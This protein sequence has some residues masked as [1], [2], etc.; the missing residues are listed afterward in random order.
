MRLNQV[1]KSILKTIIWFDLFDRPLLKHEVY[2][3]LYGFR[4]CQRKID[5]EIANLIKFKILDKRKNHIFLRGKRGLV[6]NQAKAERHSHAKINYLKLKAISLLSAVPFIKFVGVTGSVAYSVANKNSDIDLFIITA[7]KRLWLA[8]LFTNLNL[9]RQGFRKLGQKNRIC[10]NFLVSQD[11]LN[12]EAIFPYL[13]DKYWLAT[14]KPIAGSGY[15]E[16]INENQW[17]KK[18]FCNLEFK[19]RMTFLSSIKKDLLEKILSGGFGDQVEVWAEKKK[20]R[21]IRKN[22]HRF[23]KEGLK[24]TKNIAKIHFES[25]GKKYE[26]LYKKSCKKFSLNI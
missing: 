22:S 7:P 16:L 20:K 13:Y 11:S 2:K 19:S 15:Q 5:S 14:L 6:D 1:Q 21:I 3:F 12:F 18:Y 25:L 4:S 8:R 26:N 17:I 10:V 24:L 9:D 23:G